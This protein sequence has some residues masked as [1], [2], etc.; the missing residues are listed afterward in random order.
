MSKYEFLNSE[1]GVKNDCRLM[2]EI[3]L[4]LSRLL[5]EKDLWLR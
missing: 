1:M 2:V 5:V 4:W 3:D